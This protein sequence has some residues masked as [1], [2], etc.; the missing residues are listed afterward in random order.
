MLIPERMREVNLFIYEEDIQPVTLALARLGVVQIEEETGAKEST[1]TARWQ[2]LAATYGAQERRLAELSEIL[3]I[4]HT[5]TVLPTVLPYDLNI[6]Q[7]HKQLAATLQEA[8]DTIR[9][10]QQR[11]REAQQELT[12][13]HLLI[14]Q[15]RLLAP[16]QIP[17]ELMST[18][19]TIHLT[20]GV[21]P[22]ANLTRIQTALFR[23]PFTIIP[24]YQNGTRTLVFAATMPEHAP[25]LDRALRSAF[26]EPIPLPSEVRGLPAEALTA[27]EQR[28]KEVSARSSALTQ[29]RRQLTATWRE[30]L[31]TAW[32]RARVCHALADTISR[33]PRQG[34]VY[35]IAGWTPLSTLATV[36]TTVQA[37]TETRAI[38]EVLEPDETRLQIPTRLHNPSW[39]VP[40]E[41]LVT[42]FGIPAY[43]EIDPTLLVGL[44]FVLMYGMMFGDIGHGLLLTLAGLLL[45]R[46]KSGVGQLAPVLITAGTSAVL[47][48]VLYG[49]VLGMSLLSP[50]WVRPLDSMVD[51]LLAAVVAGIIVLNLGFT[52]QITIAARTRDWATLLFDK[53]GLVGFWLYWTLL[54]GG[55]AVW[56][57]NLTA[58]HW[59]LLIL[60]PTLLLFCNGPL[61]RML[62]G[63]RPLV[64]GGWSEYS[65]LAFFELFEA[66]IAYAGNSLSFVRLGA[67]AVA[68]EGL[69][70]VVLLLAGE[71]GSVRWPLAM[72]LGTLL[73][74]GF[75]G[76]IVG[77]QTLRL[78]YYEFFGKFFRGDGRPFTPLHIAGLS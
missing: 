10:W 40:F 71:T 60:T 39:L 65:V 30:L 42:T 49:T 55:F 72:A 70:Q 45:R 31:L 52:L 23:I 59:L 11:E 18:L 16:V 17:V 56:Q 44:T 6:E 66:F 13:L 38:I 12:H 58:N 37:I 24:S 75:E 5:A 77:I 43:D 68:H 20:V 46:R 61:T 9:A 26:F 47:F 15:L 22:T 74:V 51:L 36:T 29:E 33:L 1:R 73:I 27:L 14:E 76:L 69:S 57:G 78:E 2:S 28:E 8:D 48:G 62:Q 21:M 54:G 64:V 19:Q 35:L 4:D 50:L 25:I 41:G 67:F 63:Q 53:N 7:E 34:Q 3:A 32:N